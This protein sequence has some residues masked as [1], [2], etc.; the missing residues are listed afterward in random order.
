MKLDPR[1]GCK[2]PIFRAEAIQRFVDVAPR[3]VLVQVAVDANVDVLAPLRYEDMDHRVTPY[4][5]RL[6]IIL[7]IVNLLESGP[8]MA[9]KDILVIDIETKNS[10]ADVG[11]QH[12]LRNLDASLIC[13]YSYNQDKYYLIREGKFHEISDML[14]NAGLI[15][16]FS[17]NRFDLPVMNKYYKFNLMSLPRL[18]LLDEIENAHGRR[19]SLDLLANANLGY[20]KTGHGLDA[21]EYYKKGDWEA[22]EKYCQQDVK[23]TKELYDLAKKQKHLLVPQ[24]WNAN[25]VKVELDIQDVLMTSPNTLF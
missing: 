1:P 24:K 25:H 22:L 21:I 23:V 10:F 13:A 14:Q 3:G 9:N 20:G 11:G 15:V 19:I 16:G 4:Y 2:P 6:A 12:N 17:I 18:D 7:F 5:F 8:I